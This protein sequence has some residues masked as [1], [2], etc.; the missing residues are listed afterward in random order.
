MRCRI[1]TSKIALVAGTAYLAGGTTALIALA[2]IA[3]PLAGLAGMASL[4]G[5]AA[6]RIATR[7]PDY[8]IIKYPVS[9]SIVVEYKK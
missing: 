6:H 2:P 7:N 1:Y 5:I 9:S 8:E 3:A 4:A